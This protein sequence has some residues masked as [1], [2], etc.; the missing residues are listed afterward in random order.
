[1]TTQKE[2]VA[3]SNRAIFSFELAHK[4]SAIKIRKEA[5]KIKKSVFE[6][7]SSKFFS[8]DFFV[9]PM[10]MKILSIW[11]FALAASLARS[12]GGESFDG[13]KNL[14]NFVTYSNG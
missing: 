8:F 4:N 13:N 14:G 10:K 7:V 1:M 6:I 11:I 9:V 2:S 12:Q 3:A 5:S